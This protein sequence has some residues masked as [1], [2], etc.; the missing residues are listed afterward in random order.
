MKPARREGKL[1]VLVGL[2]FALEAKP[3]LSCQKRL[4]ERF[5]LNWAVRAQRAH[6][7]GP[8][9]FFCPHEVKQSA[10]PREKSAWRKYEHD[11][12][13]PRS[14]QILPSI[15]LNGARRWVQGTAFD[16]S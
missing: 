12:R 2:L 8:A 13:L 14:M 7:I 9:G 5:E 11:S 6:C 1:W 16:P 15:W 10:R 3:I 4:R